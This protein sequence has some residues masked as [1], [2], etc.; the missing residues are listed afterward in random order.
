MFERS[1]VWRAAQLDLDSD[2]AAVITLDDQ[3][4]L[5]LAAVGPQMPNS[6]SRRLRVNADRES[7]Q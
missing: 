1:C 6:R 3:V 5:M 4:D 2:H 7:D